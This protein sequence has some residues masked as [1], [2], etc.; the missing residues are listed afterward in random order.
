MYCHAIDESESNDYCMIN[1]YCWLNYFQKH[2]KLV[3]QILNFSNGKYIIEIFNNA[4]VLKRAACS[5]TNQK[6]TIKKN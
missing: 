5:I 4:N 2:I 1:V 6:I 3:T